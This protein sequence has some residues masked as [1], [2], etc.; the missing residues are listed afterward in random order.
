[1]GNE[2]DDGAWPAGAAEPRRVRLRRAVNA[3]S[4]AT[5]LGLALARYGRAQVDAGPDGLLL[6]TG[7]SARLPAPRAPA[8]TVGDVVLLRMSRQRALAR[9]GLIAHESR[10]ATQWACWLG[11]WGFLLAYGL[12]S[13]WSLLRVG[14][15]ATA[16]PFEV[17][18]GLVDG[19]YRIP[20]PRGR[21]LR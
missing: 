3:F 20:V 18:A 13:L 17:R 5:P 19:G 11:P 2:A 12:A 9:P 14:D 15:A 21:P 16:N 1:M 8:I 10:H 4:L 7:Y 6:A